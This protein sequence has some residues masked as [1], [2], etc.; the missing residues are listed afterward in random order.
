M[1]ELVE[2]FRKS[3]PLDMVEVKKMGK[4]NFGEEFPEE[5]L[6]KGVHA[7]LDGIYRMIEELKFY[8]KEWRFVQ[9]LVAHCLDLVLIGLLTRRNF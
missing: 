9:V 1:P 4:G 8:K 2:H 7:A 6:K 3:Y 5:P